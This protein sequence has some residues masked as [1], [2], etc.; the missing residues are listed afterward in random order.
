MSGSK[1]SVV[2]EHPVITPVQV[3]YTFL[4]QTAS[5]FPFGGR[6]AGDPPILAGL[7]L[8]ATIQVHAAPSPKQENWL[9]PGALRGFAVGDRKC[10]EGWHQRLTRDWRGEWWWGLCVPDR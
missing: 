10:D 2:R 8:L 3:A 7:A 4:T 9:R 6:Y 1:A 5:T